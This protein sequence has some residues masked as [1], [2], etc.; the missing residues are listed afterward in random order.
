MKRSVSSVLGLVLVLALGFVTTARADDGWKKFESSEYGFRM[1]IPEATKLA[2]A[3]SPSKEW[4]GLYA[5]LGVVELWGLARLGT[6]HKHFDI[7]AFGIRLTKIPRKQWTLVTSG[8]DTNGFEAFRIATATV[9]KYAIGAVYGVGPKGSY[10]LVLK[11]TKVDYAKHKQAYERWARS[12]EV[13]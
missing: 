6:K 12:I 9:G 8:K 10:L 4:G 13:F 3:S 2:A 5:K 1:E 7:E 11:T